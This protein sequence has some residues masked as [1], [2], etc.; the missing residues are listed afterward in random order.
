MLRIQN[1]PEK[2][3]CVWNNNNNNNTATQL[4]IHKKCFHK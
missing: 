1:I 2:E 4:G 3:I